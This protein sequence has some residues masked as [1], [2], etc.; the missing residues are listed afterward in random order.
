M[1][2]R[3]DQFCETNSFKISFK[4]GR[5]RSSDGKLPLRSKIVV[6]GV[7]LEQVTYFCFLSFDVSYE[8]YD[9]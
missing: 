2:Y 1:G 6:E 4:N 8:H 7:R 5:L 3:S 9:D